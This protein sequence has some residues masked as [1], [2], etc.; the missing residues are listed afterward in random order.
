MWNVCLDLVPLL[1]ALVVPSLFAQGVGAIVLQWVT[2]SP[3][4][5]TSET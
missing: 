1:L 2:G 5:N 4:L 3:L